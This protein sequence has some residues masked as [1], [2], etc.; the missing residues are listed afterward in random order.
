MVWLRQHEYRWPESTL[1]VRLG[2]PGICR[3]SS[4]NIKDPLRKMNG[5]IW[6]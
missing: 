1:E 4:K 6:I 3:L 5:V 2:F